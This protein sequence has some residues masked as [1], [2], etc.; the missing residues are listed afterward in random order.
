MLF[1]AE[2]LTYKEITT[3]IGFS[4]YVLGAEFVTISFL[5]QAYQE[6]V[7]RQTTREGFYALLKRHGWRKITPIPEHPK[8]ANAKMVLAS[9]NKIFIQEG[10]KAL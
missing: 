4:K 8:K 2:G 3:L 9:K 5:Y 7:G 1:R 10:E 6:R